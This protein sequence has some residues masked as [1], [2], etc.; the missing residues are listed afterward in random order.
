MTEEPLPVQ[1]MPDGKRYYP[2]QEELNILNQSISKYFSFPERSQERST[3]AAEI[4]DQL[5]K[6]SQHWTKRAVRLWFNN[7][8]TNV[9]SMKNDASKNSLSN[10]SPH[11][12]Q[13]IEQQK[14][15]AAQARKKQNGIQFHQNQQ[16]YQSPQSLT[17]EQ[18]Q[19]LQIL[20][21]SQGKSP[22][23]DIS[24]IYQ[25]QKQQ[26]QLNQQIQKTQQQQQ[27]QQIQQPIQIPQN[28]RQQPLT[29]PIPRPPSVHFSNTYTISQSNTGLPPIQRQMPTQTSMQQF[30]QQ[31]Q[32]QQNFVINQ[33][34]N[35]NQL[36]P[37]RSLSPIIARS[38]SPSTSL[39]TVFL[40]NNDESDVYM[41]KL[42][43]CIQMVKVE[44]ANIN[45]IGKE[46]DQIVSEMHSKDIFKPLEIPKQSFNFPSQKAQLP[47]FSEQPQRPPSVDP[48][49]ALW[50]TRS[51]NSLT[52]DCFDSAFNGPN[53]SVYV[54][55]E[56][57]SPNRQIRY[58]ENDK[59]VDL[60][61]GTKDRIESICCD[62]KFC[63][64]V[65]CSSVI[66]TNLAK[67]KSSAEIKL[68]KNNFGTS[69]CAL[70]H[71]NSCLVGF[72]TEST[73]YYVTQDAKFRSI[74]PNDLPKDIGIACIDCV[75]QNVGE[76]SIVSYTNSPSLHIIS[77]DGKLIRKLIG[78]TSTVTSMRTYSN[79]CLTIS[80]DKTAK[81]WDIRY[82]TPVLSFSADKKPLH[83]CSL[84]SK[85][86]LLCTTD[87]TICVFD[88]RAAKPL[89]GVSTGDYLPYSPFLDEKL[90]QFSFFGIA[91]KDGMINDSLLFLGDD[92]EN[93][94]YVY[95]QYKPFISKYII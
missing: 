61:L 73:I 26:Y 19:Q 85:Y 83:G 58:V 10:L 50:Q 44:N 37:P 81:V 76:G 51:F 49:G 95:R 40:S 27:Q 53:V 91:S 6:I 84:C 87:K 12:K 69:T 29:N 92:M 17:P 52:I 90:D 23:I 3:F 46:F 67:K 11:H 24:Q 32:Q 41:D 20:Q 93:T 7:N 8:K 64:S 88:L 22:Q 21:Q 13:I 33:Q 62:E 25:A 56:P 86:A 89:L 75:N 39:Q 14:I 79:L 60:N 48:H 43:K 59:W 4:S 57:S 74:I 30:Q 77:P 47:Y 80:E 36:I 82:N 16:L 18:L 68:S 70:T 45:Q 65:S 5:Q 72:S 54:H 78:H 34:Q 2:Q 42:I 38:S 35:K 71:N 55:P 9:P 94:K 28:P 31:Q 15:L 1:S 63:Y 66:V